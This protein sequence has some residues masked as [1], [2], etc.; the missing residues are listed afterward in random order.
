MRLRAHW[1]L[2]FAC[3]SH[4]RLCRSLDWSASVSS[5]AA[6]VCLGSDTSGFLG[7]AKLTLRVTALSGKGLS[8]ALAEQRRSGETWRDEL[9]RFSR[10]VNLVIVTNSVQSRQ[11][12]INEE[13]ACKRIER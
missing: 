6:E 11:N 8:V 4:G 10:S 9:P 2:I 12:L 3:D 13:V 1:L 5:L 7:L